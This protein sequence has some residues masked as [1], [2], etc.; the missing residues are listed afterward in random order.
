[1]ANIK[2]LPSNISNRIAAGEVV[3][4]P[5]SVV[6]ELIENSIDAD[7]SEITLIVST[8]GKALIQVL[9]NG[10]GM[11]EEDAK[12]CFLRHSTSKISTFD[13]L[14][15]IKTL[16]FRGEALA[17]IASISQVEIKTRTDS[18]DVGTLIKIEGNEITETSK[19]NCEKGTSVA[20]K[21]LFYNTPAR[22]NFLKSDSTE[23][24]YIYNTFIKLAISNPKI[25]FKFYNNGEELFDLRSSVLSDRIR[26]I[27]KYDVDSSFVEVNEGNKFLRLT[28]FIS[29]PNF[30]KKT[31][32]EQFFYLNNRYFISKNL[33]YSV[34]TA[35]DDL[36]EKGN[37]PSYFLFIEADPKKVD[38][39]V[40][41]SKLEIKFDD[42]SAVFGFIRK[43]I[44]DTLAKN[45]L[46][47][48]AGF[49]GTE[50]SSGNLEFR[51]DKFK[52]A[53]GGGSFGTFG[54][55]DFSKSNIHSI[56]EAAK[57]IENDLE[58]EFAGGDSEEKK[59]VLEHEAKCESEIFN[60]WQ[61][62]HKY[63]LCQTETG[64]L[65]IDQHAA[66]ERVLYE[67]VLIALET[68][69]P[70][71]QQLLLPLDIEFTKID[72]E[73]LKSLQTELY[74][75]GFNI[76]I[77]KND[78]VQVNGV[79]SDVRIGDEKKIL[80]EL[81]EQYKEY[82]LKLNLEKRDNLAKSFACKSAI[83]TGD[84]LTRDEMLNLIDSLFA[85][86]LPYVCPHGRP[87][88][89]RITSDELDKRFSRT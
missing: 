48:E 36:I 67:K 64:L 60:I 74:N 26:Q 54:K 12:I 47:F 14:D 86:K 30:L 38:V 40:H 45:D 80:Q 57:K 25:N 37:Y 81:I 53:S 73:I 39:N 1:M 82:E 85:S 69:S 28:G 71:S 75:L 72:Y 11:S 49:S 19:T 44:R 78:I 42:E 20:V 22:R 50:G 33:S 56:F 16:G 34:F 8:G 46:I 52:S 84:K 43:V 89:I 29:K 15:E 24:K 18:A 63:I 4:R 59:D 68:Q 76:T 21:N 35:Y 61:F 9:D 58:D 88:I 51:S 23:F 31:S 83:K 32:Q 41:P 62:K 13:D 79:P 77:L 7:A 65:I 3:S 5:E 66:H 6:K 17:S 87:T 55:Q 27:F 70:F 2:I 10:S